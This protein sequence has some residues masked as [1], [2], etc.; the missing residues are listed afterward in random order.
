MIICNIWDEGCEQMIQ[1]LSSAPVGPRGPADIHIYIYIYI[2]SSS[3]P[4]VLKDL[5]QEALAH[6]KVVRVPPI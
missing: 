6:E 2:Y 5:H 4:K 1:G 3:P